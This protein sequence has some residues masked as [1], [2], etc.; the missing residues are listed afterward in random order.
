VD[1]VPDLGFTAAVKVAIE[2]N[3]P[4]REALY[5]LVLFSSVVRGD[6]TPGLS[7]IDFLAVLRRP[8][9]E[10][11]RELKAMLEEATRSLR[12][13]WWTCPGRWSTKLGTP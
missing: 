4:L 8:A 11:K 10:A 6:Y 2:A 1:A 5:S 12:P 13:S 3:T 7:D 9:D